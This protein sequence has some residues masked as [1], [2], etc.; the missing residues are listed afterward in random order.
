MGWSGPGAG[1]GGFGGHSGSWLHR[2]G[3]F[4][5]T[6]YHVGTVLDIRVRVHITFL[7]LVVFECVRAGEL[8]WPLRWTGLL[9]ASVL[10]HEFGHCLACRRVGG[11]ADDIL[12]WPLGGLAF[13]APPRR[14]WP[15]FVTVVWGPLVNLIIAAASFAVL[16][17][18]TAGAMPVSLNPLHPWVGFAPSGPAGWVADLYVVNSSL[19]WFN[20][21]LLFYPF[22]GGRLVQIALWARYGFLRSMRWALTLG[23]VGAVGAALFGIFAKQLFITAIGVFGF[24]TCRQQLKHLRFAQ[25]ADQETESWDPGYYDRRDDRAGTRASLLQQWKNRRQAH[26]EQ[27]QCEQVA[28]RE[29][30]MDRV[31]EKIA[32]SGMDS[33]SKQEQRVLHEATEQRRKQ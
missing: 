7:L 21:A 33:L 8:W 10:L 28:R 14:P 16:A 23:M 15:E 29:A 18:W 24:L 3:A 5:N 22:D 12:L 32:R 13:C 9:F 20:L 25:E 19:L 30:E 2:V 6:S 4:L 26:H 31:L 27:R 11:S 1:P 17:V